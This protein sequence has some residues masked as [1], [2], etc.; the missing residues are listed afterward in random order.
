LACCSVRWG[1]LVGA[2]ALAELT[3]RFRIPRRITDRLRGQR[4]VGSPVLLPIV[5]VAMAAPGKDG[6][7]LFT[8]GEVVVRQVLAGAA[9]GV[10]IGWGFAFLRQR[11]T[12]LP[13]HIA[14]AIGTPYA[15]AL[16]ASAVGASPLIAPMAAGFVSYATFMGRRVE[17]DY[18]PAV[19]RGNRQFWQVA[20]YVL[21][22]V[23]TLLVA[24]MTRAAIAD[25]GTRSLRS[26]VITSL[27][28]VV[29]VIAVRFGVAL[30]TNRPRASDAWPRLSPI[31]DAAVVAWSGIRMPLALL[32]ALLIPQRLPSG[33]A[34]PDR[35]LIIAVTALGLILSQVIQSPT[36]RPLLCLTR[37][38][39][40]PTIQEEEMAARR[41]AAQAAV[42]ELD[43]VP[44]PADGALERIRDRHRAE[45]S[46]QTYG[47][48]IPGRRRRGSAT[49]GTH[50]EASSP[51]TAPRTRHDR[52]LRVSA[53]A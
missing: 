3:P 12:H 24:F 48:W 34:F 51:D 9:A 1:A 42:D 25:A 43:R 39:D 33:A 49:D 5:L 35:D 52:R 14:L 16:A 32:I 19:R 29:A 50:S 8:I 38:V 23:A 41:L 46:D 11:A 27:A 17:T 7:L 53:A 10:V 44:L 6:N 37:A 4:L 2:D 20:T 47:G 22:A 13:V 18:T 26:L 21:N 36:L 30:V 28:V 40:D 45:A 15:S 31:A